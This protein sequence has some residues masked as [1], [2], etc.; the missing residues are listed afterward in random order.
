[1]ICVYIDMVNGE[2]DLKCR[3][4]KYMLETIK[5]N[6]VDPVIKWAHFFITFTTIKFTLSFIKKLRN[7][8]SFVWRTYLIKYQQL[9]VKKKTSI[10]KECLT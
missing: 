2:L 3:I 7:S 10:V 6:T 5:Y 4:L 1:L 8:R 9:K